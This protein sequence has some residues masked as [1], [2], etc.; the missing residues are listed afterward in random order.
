M[1][2]IFALAFLF[3]IIGNL[4]PDL[5]SFL[6]SLRQYAGNWASATW[7][8]RPG[9]EERLSDLPLV[10]NLTDQL[11]AM[12]Y[13]PNDAEMTLQK[14]LGWRGMHSQGRGLYSLLLDHLDDLNSRTVREGEFVCNTV[15][16]WN[17]GDG[18]LH[19]DRMVAAVQR[20]L[21]L[22]PGD[23]VVMYVESQPIHKKTQ[24]YRVI[25]AALGVVERGTWNVA[26]CIEEQPWLPNGPVPLKVSWTADG[27]V[28]QETLTLVRNQVDEQKQKQEQQA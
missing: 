15:L 27:Y 8:M 10:T 22:A 26:D 28:R 1:I 11:V 3:P 7:A 19:D 12:K 9:V 16:G 21:Q 20:R 25:D 14:L 5:V 24:E 13:E 6:P 17:F 18:H 4:R 23:L 2:P